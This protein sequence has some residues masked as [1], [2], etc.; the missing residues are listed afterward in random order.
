MNLTKIKKIL[1]RMLAVFVE[2]G[3]DVL[4]AGAIAGV[5]LYQSVFMAGVLGVAVVLKSLAKSYI[6]D[7]DLSDDDVEAAFA[8]VQNTKKK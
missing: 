5:A 4:G 8:E 7:G 2:K 1:T 6:A 3:L